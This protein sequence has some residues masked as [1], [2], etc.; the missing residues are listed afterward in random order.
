LK[1]EGQ[2]EGKRMEGEGMR[3]VLEFL[4]S[5]LLGKD[6]KELRWA[7]CSGD[8]EEVWGGTPMYSQKIR[9]PHCN[10]GAVLVWS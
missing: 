2:K 1:N 8:G 10:F 5:G 4:R 3:N 6:L 7:G 9:R